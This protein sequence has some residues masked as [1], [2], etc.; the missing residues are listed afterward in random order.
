MADDV[1]DR[2][3]TSWKPEKVMGIRHPNND[4]IGILESLLERARSAEIVGIA[5]ATEMP[6][7]SVGTGY[8]TRHNLTILGGI[9]WLEHRMVDD[10]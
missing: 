10:L 6:D 3:G 5:Y 9:R 2:D 7:G 4:L 8:T 1:T